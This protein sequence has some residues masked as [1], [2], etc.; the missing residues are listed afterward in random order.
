M[1]QHLAEAHLTMRKS[2]VWIPHLQD[3]YAELVRGER[4]GGTYDQILAELAE[5]PKGRQ[6]AIARAVAPLAARALAPIVGFLGMDLTDRAKLEMFEQM[7][8]GRFA[9]VAG[10]SMMGDY[11]EAQL[12]KHVFRNTAI[13]T[14]PANVAVHLYTS[15][16]SDANSTGTEVTGGS[17]ATVNVGT[18]SGWSDPGSTGGLTDNAADVDF[19]TASAS[20]GTVSHVSLEV[21]GGANRLFHGALTASKTV[22]SGDTFKFAT[23]ALD[24]SVA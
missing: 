21:A 9:P 18:T 20:W 5:A 4:P 2:G 10:G 16:T 1:T 3:A 19:G 13:F 22:G 14:P 24:V 23:G 8:K 17:Y 11:L 6:A 7:I 15:A 12:M